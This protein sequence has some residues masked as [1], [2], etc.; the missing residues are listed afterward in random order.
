VKLHTFFRSSTSFRLRIALNWKGLP[1]ESVYTSL[2]KMQHKDPAYLALNPQGLVP[3][4]VTDEGKAYTQSMAMIEWLDER[5]PEPPLMPEDADEKWYV[6]AVSQ[7]I[8]CEIH[9]L[10]NVRVLKYLKNNYGLDDAKVNGGWYAHWTAEGLTALE[11]FVKLQGRSGAYCLGERVTMADVCL[12][13]QIFNAQ[14]FDCDLKPYPV[15]VK[16]FERCMELKPF[17]D[18]HPARQADSA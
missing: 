4:L 6:R 16:I 17:A 8:G 7:I 15:L 10:N 9:P 3:A 11:A 5:Y 1:Y 2:P 13:P 18:A 12:V 14:R